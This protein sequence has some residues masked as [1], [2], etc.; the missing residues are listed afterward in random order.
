[1]KPS[2][3]SRA[4][5]APRRRRRSG[6]WGSLLLGGVLPCLLLLAPTAA[7]AWCLGGSPAATSAAGGL[8]LTTL[9]FVVGFGA[10]RLVLAGPAFGQLGFALGVYGLQVLALLALVDVVP[11]APGFH[12]R[13]FA[14]GGLVG[15]L[16]WQ[17]GQ[18][19]ALLRGRHPI[20]PDVRLPGEDA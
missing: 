5:S 18:V 6:V 12:A 1:M 8:L 15:A 16:A 9:F 19:T 11:A 2:T 7:V 17:A 10:L 20:Y 3:T 4:P 13:A 14:A